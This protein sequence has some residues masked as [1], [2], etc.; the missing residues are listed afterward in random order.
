VLGAA[1]DLSADVVLL[2]ATPSTASRAAKPD[3]AGGG[4][5]SAA[6]LPVVILPG[7]HDPAIGHRDLSRRSLNA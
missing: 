1:R 2:A 3:R 6:A 5:I 4:V 7:N